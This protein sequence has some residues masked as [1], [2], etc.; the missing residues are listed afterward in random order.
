MDHCS[1][2]WKFIKHDLCT[3]VS[4]QNTW[5][6]CLLNK[7]SKFHRSLVGI[8]FL[9]QIIIFTLIGLAIRVNL[10]LCLLKYFQLFFPIEDAWGTSNRYKDLS[11]IQPLDLLSSVS[12]RQTNSKSMKLSN[13]QQLFFSSIET[14]F[15][16][17]VFSK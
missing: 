8:L 4:S 14:L 7:R 13:P 17:V 1:G 15:Y 12:P 5:T 2:I 3:D 9:A 10:I 6:G 11:N 16:V